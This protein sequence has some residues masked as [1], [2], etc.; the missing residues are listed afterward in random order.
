ML[1]QLTGEQ[2]YAEFGRQCFEASLAGKRDRDDRY[3]FMG[4]GSID[5]LP[6]EQLVCTCLIVSNKQLIVI[7][8]LHV[9]A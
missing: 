8:Y 1:Y 9:V 3:S 5:S 4:P 7:S 6:K 2:K